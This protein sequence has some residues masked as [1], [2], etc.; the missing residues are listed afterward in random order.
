MQEWFGLFDIL[1]IQEA[2]IDCTFPDSQFSIQGY[3]LYRRDRK[4][5]GGGFLLYI[6][7][8]I[9][10]YQIKIKCVEVEA[11]LVVIE[12]SQQH[13]SLLSAYKPTSVKNEIFNKV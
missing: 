10:S 2:K 11:I 13:S 6:R 3:S 12:V 7:N 4:K 8:S 5:G 9:P 1:S